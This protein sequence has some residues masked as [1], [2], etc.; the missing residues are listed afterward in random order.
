VQLSWSIASPWL[1]YLSPALGM[2][3]AAITYRWLHESKQ[4]RW[5]PRTVVIACGLLSACFGFYQV[6]KSGFLSQSVALLSQT[7]TADQHRIDALTG[8]LR[9]A[10]DAESVLRSK[11]TAEAASIGDLRSQL[12]LSEA[13][14]RPDDLT[15][16]SSIAEAKA[17]LTSNRYAIAELQS[18]TQHSIIEANAASLQSKRTAAEVARTDAETSARSQ[19]AFL[20]A[21]SAAAK[22]GVFHFSQ[23]ILTSVA[24]ALMK[25]PRGSSI[26]ACAPNLET[27]CDDLAAAFRRAGW[28]APRVIKGAS[29]WTG[30]GLDAPTDP[31]PS[32]GLTIFY[33]PND[34]AI[35]RTL[36]AL[37]N[38]S[39]FK[40]T[41]FATAA[42]PI[43]LD[44][45]INI[46][47]VEH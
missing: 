9:L 19:A 31:D 3:A 1:G 21:Q 42:S 14:R 7:V 11:A 37:L 22:A 23:G 43:E 44:I 18:Q 16:N 39:G 5:W 25:S 30:G 32:S 8:G 13:A 36:V 6:Y 34:D 26:I 2:I 46:R 10:Q 24:T 47:F 17:R 29:F 40:V 12:Q 4:E 20:T 33:S 15:L 35:S 38:D 28:P 45:G 27:A 41:R